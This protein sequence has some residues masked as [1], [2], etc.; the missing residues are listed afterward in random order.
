MA[1]TA[2]LPAVVLLFYIY[3]R[4]K[5]QREPVSQ[6]LK[7]VGFGVLSIPVTLVLAMLIGLIGLDAW[8]SL[9][10]HP[11]VSTAFWGA[12]IPEE[13]AKLLL[14]WLFL[15][16]N[17]YFDEHVDGIVYAVAVS[18]GFAAVENVM[19]VF[20]NA[21]NWL[22]VGVMR[23]LFSVPGHYAFAV[24]M[25]YYYS[26]ACFGKPEHRTRNLVLAWVAPVLAHGVFDSLLFL[27][28]VTPSA[29]S[30]ILFVL[31]FVFC[32]YMHK[33]ARKRIQEHLLRDRAV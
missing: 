32:Y 33:Y 17:R 31:F 9:L 27:S 25:G 28:N 2:L 20:Q 10:V 13:S 26:L 4:D 15:R 6:I 1:I 24:F 8:T 30:G 12:A 21:D 3:R 5:Y 23:A 16:K 22:S 19:Y 11:Q 18:M 7:G 29:L 14:L